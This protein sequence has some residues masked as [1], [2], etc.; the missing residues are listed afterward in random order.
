MD[1]RVWTDISRIDQQLG[2]QRRMPPKPPSIAEK[3]PNRMGDFD[4][5]RVAPDCI[6]DG[7]VWGPTKLHSTIAN[8]DPTKRYV[9]VKVSTDPFTVTE[10][11]VLPD[12]WGEDEM[13]YDKHTHITIVITRF[14]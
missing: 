8:S 14:G 7:N 2:T 11:A 10:L 9:K 4:K 6:F 13:I 5:A 3:I 12:V 1:N